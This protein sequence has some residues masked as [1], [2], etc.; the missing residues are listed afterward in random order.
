MPSGSPSDSPI[1]L[2]CRLRLSFH[3][4]RFTRDDLAANYHDSFG[5]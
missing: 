3:G 2:A 5:L 1:T 4:A